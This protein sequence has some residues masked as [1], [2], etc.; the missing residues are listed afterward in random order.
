[1]KV[2]IFPI[3]TMQCDTQLVRHATPSHPDS[4]F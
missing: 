4:A 2:V 1:M 3:L